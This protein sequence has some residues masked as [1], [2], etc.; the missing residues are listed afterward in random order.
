[1]ILSVMLSE[2][3]WYCHS[4]CCH[5]EFCY[6]E[7]QHDNTRFCVLFWVTHF[8][9]AILT[10][11]MQSVVILNVSMTPLDSGCYAEWGILVLPFCLLSCSVVILNASTT[12]LG[13]G[14]HAVWRILLLLFWLLSCRVLLC[15][16]CHIERHY[17]EC[18]YAEH[19]YV[20]RF[21]DNSLTTRLIIKIS[22]ILNVKCVPVSG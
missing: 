5:A 12:T 3:F 18:Q 10:V 21:N 1:M 8:G 7:C 11:V 14:C 17:T 9:T 15:W 13:S 22:C 4:D 6:S 16:S 19:Y 2:A 20:L